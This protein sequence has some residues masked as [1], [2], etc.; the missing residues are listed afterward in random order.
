M[1]GGKT[2]ASSVVT[3]RTSET[4]TALDVTVRLAR[5][6]E[7]VSRG[8][9]QQVPGASVNSNVTEEADALVF[10]FTLSSGDTI[11]P[12]TYTFSARYTYAEGGRDAGADTYAV[13]ATGGSGAALTAGGDFG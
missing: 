3:I 2:Q 1:V 5:T 8:G 13:T 12:G 11:E 9:S 4:L 6:A 10:H 7:L